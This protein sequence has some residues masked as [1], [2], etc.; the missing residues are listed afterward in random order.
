MTNIDKQKLTST[1]K[2]NQSDTS[3]KR[4]GVKQALD[5]I[6]IRTMPKKYKVSS[7]EQDNKTKIIGVTIMI[8][9]SFVLIA[10]I[11]LSYIYIIKPDST[12]VIKKTVPIVEKKENKP[13]AVENSQDKI[14]KEVVIP[15]QNSQPMITTTTEEATTAAAEEIATTTEVITTTTSET[16]NV[17]TDND[18]LSDKEEIILG[19]NKE[20]V[21]TDGDT[22]NDLAELNNLYNPAGEG[23]VINNKNI[24][25]YKSSVFNYSILRPISWFKQDANNGGSVIFGDIDGS[26]IQIIVQANEKSENIQEWYAKQ[27]PQEN[28]STK[29]VISKNNWYGIFHQ[30]KKIFYLT[31][32]NKKHIYI[33]S[34]ISE[35][36]DN[37]DYN[38]IFNMMINSFSID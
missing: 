10:L 34:Y 37:L 1:K 16:A 26:F 22:Y 28:I 15:K 4:E 14:K 27:F 30:N 32:S 3:V 31:D 12:K 11:Y 6:I 5:N 35:P 17:D 9:G 8:L 24:K 20:L 13:H 36:E 21:D 33:I 7:S 2:D 25:E 38:N 23:S 29:K 18:G 19:T